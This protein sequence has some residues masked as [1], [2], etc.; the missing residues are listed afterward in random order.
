MKLILTFLLTV[1][2]HL[3]RAQ[4]ADQKAILDV[5]QQ[6]F[7]AQVTRNAEV[8]EKVLSDDL[9]YVHSS[10]QVDNKKSFIQSI[11]EAKMIL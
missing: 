2:L 11:L 3:V 8:M 9:V 5:E 10:G 4:S 1:S 6:R 7:N